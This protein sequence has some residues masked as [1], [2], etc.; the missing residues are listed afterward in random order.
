[1]SEGVAKRVKVNPS[2][3]KPML[4][5]VMSNE[6]GEPSVYGIDRDALSESQYKKLL[7]FHREGPW[8]EGWTTHVDSVLFKIG[9][10]IPID[11]YLQPYVVEDPD[12]I[13][14]EVLITAVVVMCGW[15]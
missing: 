7:E 5:V 13:S 10:D 1:M 6:S 11:D 14:D 2:D 8:K 15:Q 12:T 3:T 9:D 4:V